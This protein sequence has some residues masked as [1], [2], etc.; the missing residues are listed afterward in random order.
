MK[1]KNFTNKFFP[2]KRKTTQAKNEDSY[3]MIKYQS[4]DDSIMEV[5]WNGTSLI[6][7]EYIL[8]RSKKFKLYK[9]EVFQEIIEHYNPSIGERYFFYKTKEDYVQERLPVLRSFWNLDFDNCN[10]YYS[11]FEEYVRMQVKDPEKPRIKLVTRY[12]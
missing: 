4:A 3:R 5:V 9:K 10:N 6:P 11:T 8:D 7:P 12:K 1:L 2:N